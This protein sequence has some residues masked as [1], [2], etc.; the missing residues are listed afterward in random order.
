[1][2]NTQFEKYDKEIEEL[3]IFPP[4]EDFETTIVQEHNDD[5][6]K[7][8][9]KKEKEYSELMDK[10][11]KQGEEKCIEL[12]PTIFTNLNKLANPNVNLSCKPKTDENKEKDS[13][14]I[15]QTLL[16]FMKDGDAEFK[17]KMGRNMTYS[18]MR[19]LYG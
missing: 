11:E 14:N 10:L 13:E 6:D 15:M 9:E 3:Y 17:E 18:E 12:L 8:R 1:M 16:E 2:E 19:Q 5:E 7:I 4:T